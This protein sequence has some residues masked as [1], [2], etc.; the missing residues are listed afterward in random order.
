[1]PEEKK[2]RKS[3]IAEVRYEFFKTTTQMIVGAFGL[4][5]ALAWNSLVQNAIDRYFGKG[6]G[7]KSGLIYAVA[8]TV[9]AVAVSF[10][11]GT[12]AARFKKDIDDT[13]N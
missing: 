3:R 12:I 7:L 9:I 8:V 2:S 10:Y 1:M 6:E 11:L 5:A 4:V 13:N